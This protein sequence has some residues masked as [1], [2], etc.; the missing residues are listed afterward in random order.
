MTPTMP[1]SPD[2]PRSEVDGVAIPRQPLNVTVATW[3]QISA[4]R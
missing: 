2:P 1:R 3:R 4:K